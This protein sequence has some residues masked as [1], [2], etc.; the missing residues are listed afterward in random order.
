MAFRLTKKIR[1]GDIDAAGIAYYPKIVDYFHLALEEFFA[2][3]VGL[4]YAEVITEQRIGF[5]TVHLQVDFQRPLSYGDEV[6][7]LVSVER[8]GESSVTW[9]YVIELD[10]ATCVLASVTTVTVNLDNLRPVDTP[11]AIREVLQGFVAQAASRGV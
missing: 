1:F 10:G 6:D 2:A 4:P 11:E 9:S 8:C 3:E 7:I 5:P